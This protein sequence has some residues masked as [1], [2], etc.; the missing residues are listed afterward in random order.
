MIF[1]DIIFFRW[2]YIFSA[3]L[4]VSGC[5]EK[6]TASD[7]GKDMYVVSGGILVVDATAIASSNEQIL[8][9]DGSVMDGVVVLRLGRTIANGNG[10]SAII[11]TSSNALAAFD[12]NQDGRLD[13]HDPVWGNMHL[14]I[15]YN[16]DNT[17]GEGEYALIGECGVDAI[18]LDLGAGQAWSL[19]SDGEKKPVKLPV[20]I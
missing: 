20:A 4:A 5:T 7:S 3:L 15:D 14:A 17:I 13:E 9:R 12:A 6:R 16:G 11:D 2:V 1:R 10:D 19:H 8:G 18:E